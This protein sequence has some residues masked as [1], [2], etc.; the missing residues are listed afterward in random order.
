NLFLRTKKSRTR[1]AICRHFQT[2]TSCVEILS[3]PA[4]FISQDDEL[5]DR[6]REAGRDAIDASRQTDR[7]FG[8]R[9]TREVNASESAGRF[10]SVEVKCLYTSPFSLPVQIL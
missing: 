7:S 10:T 6:Q 5:V 9:T 8:K 2:Q 4:A 1:R 3:G